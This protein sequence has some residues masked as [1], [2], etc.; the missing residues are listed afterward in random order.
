M[1]KVLILLLVA[2]SVSCSMRDKIEIIEPVQVKVESLSKFRLT[3]MVDNR[4][5]HAVRILE[6]RLKVHM[7]AG[8]VGTILLNEEVVVPRRAVTKIDIPMRIRFENPLVM[9]VD[10]SQDMTVS[11]EVTVRIGMAR[12]KMRIK[13]QPISKFLDNF[14]E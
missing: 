13:N 9:L 11:G 2:M 1:K 4:S 10:A 14:A 5:C 12:K 7:P 6:G 3:C 8:D